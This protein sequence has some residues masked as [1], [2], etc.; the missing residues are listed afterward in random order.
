MI[1]RAQIAAWRRQIDDDV[2]D[3]KQRIIGH[4]AP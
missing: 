3:R 4:S 2:V 1:H